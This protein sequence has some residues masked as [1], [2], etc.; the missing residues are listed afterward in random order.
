MNIPVSKEGIY[1]VEFWDTHSGII[2]S[3]LDCFTDHDEVEVILPPLQ[4]DIALKIIYLG[5]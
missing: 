4:K 3:K 2:V 1:S 5:K